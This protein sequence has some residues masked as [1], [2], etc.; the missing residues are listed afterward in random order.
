MTNNSLK[1]VIRN[2]A[3]GISILAFVGCSSYSTIIK[4][5]EIKEVPG[6]QYERIIRLNN[7]EG[8]SY[9]K[10]AGLVFIKKGTKICTDYPREETLKSLE[11]LTMMEKTSSRY[12]I[13]Y[14]IEVGGETF[15]FVSLPVSYSAILWENKKEDCKYKVQIILPYIERNNFDGEGAKARAGGGDHGP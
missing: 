6:G 11:D 15:G 8:I 4:M 5:K 9:K 14:A 13:N 7:P 10:L 3:L 12:F 2:M 1:N